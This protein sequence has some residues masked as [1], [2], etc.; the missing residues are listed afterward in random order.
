VSLV[1][2]LAACAT[3]PT[4]SPSYTTRKAMAQEQVRRSEWASAFPIV[5]AL[6]AEDPG[7]AE[8]LA[9]RGIIY[10]EQKMPAEAEADLLDALRV[11]PDLAGAHSALA[12]LYDAT[13]RG[14]EALPH[15]RRA[16]ELAP[17]NPTYLNNLAFALFAHGKARDAIPVYREALRLDPMSSRIRNNLGFAYAR[18]GDFTNAAEQFSLAGGPA[19]ASNNLGFA[20]QAA[21]N[22]AQAYEAYVTALRLN[23]DLARARQN[24]AFVASRLGRTVPEDLRRDPRS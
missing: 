7:D 16:T 22:L 8:V 10:R 20:Y 15:H 24:L 14:G 18:T 1:L 4:R 9:M 3:V 19:E 5:N 6:H 11:A 17:K 23:P 13:G 12:V 2:S 21:G